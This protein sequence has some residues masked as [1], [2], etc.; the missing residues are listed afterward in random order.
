MMHLVKLREIT[1]AHGARNPVDSFDMPIGV[2]IGLL[3]G[4][5][6]SITGVGIDMIIYAT[7]V[8]LYRSDL[9]VA[10]PTSVILMAV[11][12]VAGIGSN[13]LLENWNPAVYAIDPAVFRNW[14]AAAPIVALGAP[15][16]AVVVNL[17]PAFSTQGQEEYP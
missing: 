14:L 4:V 2:F 8:L 12:S 11:T 3:G 16:G 9:K 6:S 7:L 15:L 13:L 5:V 1:A 17:A 10:V